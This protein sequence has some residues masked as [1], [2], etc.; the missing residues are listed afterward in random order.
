MTLLSSSI[1][2]CGSASRGSRSHRATAITMRP[3][4]TCSWAATPASS[5]SARSSSAGARASGISWSFNHSGLF[6]DFLAGNQSYQCTPWSNPTYNV[7][8]WQRPCYLLPMKAT[9]R[10]YR[11][12]IEDTDWDRYGVGR[13]PRCDNCMAHCGFE[14]TAVN[15]AFSSSP[16]GLEGRPQGTAG[17]G[18]DGPELPI[19]LC[20]RRHGDGGHGPGRRGQAHDPRIGRRVR[21]ESP[22]RR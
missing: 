9:R 4:R 18:A 13:N 21:G 17:R 7:F 14:G 11:S 22:F 8:G 2:R 5:C 1:P 6:L 15:D 19:R 10:R 16:Q 3:V 20:G 12:L